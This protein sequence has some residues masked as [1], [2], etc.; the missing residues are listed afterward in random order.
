MLK[1]ARLAALSVSHDA[2][3]VKWAKR[4][5]S[6]VFRRAPAEDQLFTATHSISIIASGSNRPF[7]SNSEEAG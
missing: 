2:S 6:S 7:T 3:A 5:R 1:E 4:F